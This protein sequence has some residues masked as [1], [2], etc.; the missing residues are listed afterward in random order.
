MYYI[1]TYIVIYNYVIFSYDLW[2]VDICLIFKQV[3]ELIELNINIRIINNLRDAN[4]TVSLAEYE[5]EL[6]NL[7]DQVNRNSTECGLNININ[8]TNYDNQP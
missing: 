4:D 5:Q 1:L 8:K 2:A 7:V 6:E 3:E